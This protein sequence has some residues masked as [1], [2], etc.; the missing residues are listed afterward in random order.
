MTMRCYVA[1][2]AHK[3]EITL[4]RALR[5]AN[6]PIAAPWIDSEINQT[7]HEP[8]RDAWARHW[9][10][11]LASAAEAEIT[12]FYA[13]EGSVQCGALI[14]MGAALSAGKQV[15]L[16]SY[17][18]WTIAAHPKVRRFPSLEAAIESILALQAGSRLRAAA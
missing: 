15:L 10:S 18:D 9:E 14:E 7:D 3:A 2:K 17:Y 16:V 12:L 13:P 1:S 8:S 11:C 5:A 4:W 6:V